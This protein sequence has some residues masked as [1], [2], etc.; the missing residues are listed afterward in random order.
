MQTID[1]TTK[2]DGSFKFR[3]VVERNSGSVVQYLESTAK[4]MRE[5]AEAM[6]LMHR[7]VQ[8]F[9]AAGKVVM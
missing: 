7:S 3:V 5:Q 1:H 4:G 9:D 6:Q 2:Q 8:V